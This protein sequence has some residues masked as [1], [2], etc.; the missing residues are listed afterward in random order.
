MEMEE[1]FQNRIT[2]ERKLSD[3]LLAMWTKHA[4]RVLE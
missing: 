3:G 4:T 1:A 2:W